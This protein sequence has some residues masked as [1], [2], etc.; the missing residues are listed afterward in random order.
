MKSAQ[1]RYAR[2]QDG[3]S[4][5]YQA[6]GD[7]PVDLLMT[8][9]L[10]GNVELLWEVPAVADFLDQFAAISRLLNYDRRGSGLSD[11]PR[12][13]TTM[14]TGL[15]D[16]LAVLDAVES[17][18]AALMGFMDSGAS[19]ALLAAQHPERISAFVWYL[20]TP[21]CA[22]AADY[23]WGATEED[24]LRQLTATEGSW[25]SDAAVAAYFERENPS[26]AADPALASQLAKAM[27]LTASPATALTDM[28]TWYETDVRRVLPSISVPTLVIDRDGTIPEEGEYTAS[29]IP[30]CKRVVL[31]G[32]DALPFLGDTAAVVNA[33]RE[34]LGVARPVAELDRVLATVLFTDVVGSTDKACEVGVLNVSS[35]G[36]R[37]V[38]PRPDRGAGGDPGG[39][40]LACDTHG[41]TVGFTGGDRCDDRGGRSANDRRPGCSR[42]SARSWSSSSV[43][44]SSASLPGAHGPGRCRKREAPTVRV[45]LV[46]RARPHRPTKRATTNRPRLNRAQTRPPR[47]NRAR[48][49]NP[50]SGPSRVSTRIVRSPRSA[51]SSVAVSAAR[52]ARPS[53]AARRSSCCGSVASAPR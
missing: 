36:C 35:A 25:G 51:R 42:R 17:E 21:R 47:P 15:D 13:S 24:F 30:G 41:A 8:T 1:T 14:E 20:P 28:R 50:R 6:V 26:L 37:L 5:A 52:A 53:A 34:F 33:V 29:L 27:R 49:R 44:W 46:W 19:A 40:R 10:L 43:C 32:A 11:R 18:Q 7:G 9:G 22:V 4:I 39:R 48:R 3:T 31:P 45:R 2:S 23:P 16:M 12:E 38:G